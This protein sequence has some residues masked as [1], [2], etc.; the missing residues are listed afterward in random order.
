MYSGDLLAP[1]LNVFR[2]HF[3]HVQEIYFRSFN[4]NGEL[5]GCLYSS[6]NNGYSGDFSGRMPLSAAALRAV[7]GRR[8]PFFACV[9]ESSGCL[10]GELSR[11]E[12][13]EMKKALRGF[14]ARSHFICVHGRV[15][16]S[17]LE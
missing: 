8:R 16:R 13:R 4:N 3:P 2:G 12:K 17:V 15:G 11:S 5:P 14:Y 9:N 10:L 1:G 6:D 7:F